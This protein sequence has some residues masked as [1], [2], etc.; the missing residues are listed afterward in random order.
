MGKRVFDSEVIAASGKAEQ[1][2][3][4]LD[5]VLLLPVSSRVAERSKVL[6]TP[7]DY[8]HNCQVCQVVSMPSSY[9][10]KDCKPYYANIKQ[11]DYVLLQSDYVGF[12]VCDS[13]GIKYINTSI[14]C[15]LLTYGIELPEII[16]I[17]KG[18]ATNDK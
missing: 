14:D 18:Y 7:D 17:G 1:W 8:K 12:R 16:A 11:G 4:I 9:S 6:I 5:R 3:M 15:I 2:K 10:H 13:A